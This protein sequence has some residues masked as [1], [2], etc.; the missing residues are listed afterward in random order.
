MSLQMP[1]PERRKLQLPPSGQRGFVLVMVLWGLSFLVVIASSF[2]VTTQ[3]YTKSAA[4][5]IVKA[6]LQAHADTGIHLG[7]IALLA[8]RS[9]KPEALPGIPE[10]LLT[11]EPYLCSLE[12]GTTLTI[13]IED[14]G[15]KV[16]LNW[17]SLPLLERLFEGFGAAPDQARMI[18]ARLLDYK[19]LDN[20]KS[21]EGA[22]K[23]EYIAAGLDFGPKNEPLTVAEELEQVLGLSPKLYRKV[24]PF[25]TVHSKRPGI[26][27]DVAPSRLVSALAGPIGETQPT[28]NAET[29]QQ[30]DHKL[31]AAYISTSNRSV[32]KIRAQALTISRATFIREALVQLPRNRNPPYY[33]LAWR[34]AD[35]TDGPARE[36]DQTRKRCISDE[37]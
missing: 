13:A 32:Y 1:C 35:Q 17:A 24:R 2:A 37:G 21:K 5:R 14:E 7:F 4:N 9:A 18:A 27:P 11:G 15:G 10:I 19:D 16:D 6:R 29:S 22:E 28:I 25:V 36:A 8:N 12:D 26:D 3:S 31:P 33:L 20:V 34:Q 30:Q 23:D